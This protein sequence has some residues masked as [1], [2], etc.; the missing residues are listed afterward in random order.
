M[1]AGAGCRRG[2]GAGR[3]RPETLGAGSLRRA[4][5]GGNA[6][7]VSCYRTRIIHSKDA[8]PLNA[9]AA[10]SALKP[11][12]SRTP[13]SDTVRKTLGLLDILSRGNREWY[14]AEVAK[15]AELPPS[16]AFRLLTTL[17]QLRYVDYDAQS[18][19]YRLGLKLLE[20]GHLVSQRLDLPSLAMPL[21]HRLSHASGETAH[22][23]IRDG[24][25][26]V[27]IAK[28]EAD[29][30][31][32]LHTPLGRR[33][34]LHAGA[35]MKILLAH[36]PD[37]VIEGYIA[38]Q[39]ESPS[40][41]RKPVDRDRLWAELRRV[42]AQGVCVTRSE[43]TPGA[44]GVSAAVRDH[45]GS[46]VAGLTIS[47]PEARF[48]PAKVERFVAL[49]TRAAGDLSSRLGHVK[50]EPGEDGPAGSPRPSPTRPSPRSPSRAARA[51]QSAR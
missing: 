7:D 14:A 1:R 8:R 42:R 35:S 38:R 21:L 43:Q 22:L 46:V 47:G 3:G 23:S 5:R 33:V 2:R 25:E 4:D 11:N 19:R 34:A 36:L 44:A 24:D 39:A 20:L 27:F 50:Q 15:E 6:I 45:S 10:A 40:S 18:R 13:T 16:T 41:G 30:S 17:V 29:H 51:P 49:V 28:V 26:G 37:E 12:A 9:R 48:T 31:V 32:R